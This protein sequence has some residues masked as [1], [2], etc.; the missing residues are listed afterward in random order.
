MSPAV[1]HVH[2]N[3]C[4]PL[5]PYLFLIYLLGFVQDL[6]IVLYKPLTVSFDGKVKNAIRVF[7]LKSGS[8]CV[9]LYMSPL[10]RD[11]ELIRDQTSY[12]TTTL[13]GALMA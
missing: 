3:I 4:P 8:G 12:Q 9:A 10:T 13:Q 2:D 5:T 7:L 6:L 1:P 11:S